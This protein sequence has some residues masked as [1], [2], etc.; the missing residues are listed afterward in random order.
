MSL[1][2]IALALTVA[3][4][5]DSTWAPLRWQAANG[6]RDAEY[7]VSSVAVSEGVLSVLVRRDRALLCPTA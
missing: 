5:A 1:L 3:G 6:P 7:L 2:T 4:H